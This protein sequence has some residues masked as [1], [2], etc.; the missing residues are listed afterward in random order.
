MT[1]TSEIQPF[2]REY[3]TEMVSST[4]G[5]GKLGHPPT[6][7]ARTHSRRIKVL[8]VGP[9]TG[10]ALEEDTVGKLRHGSQRRVSPQAGETK[11]KIEKVTAPSY[12]VSAGKGNR[13][14]NESQPTAGAKARAKDTSDTELLSRPRR[15]AGSWTAAN[16]TTPPRSGRGT[17]SDVLR[18]RRPRSAMSGAARRFP[19]KRAAP[20]PRRSPREDD[21]VS[22][23]GRPCPRRAVP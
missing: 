6:P 22:A 21:A 14:R 15:D 18:T 11:G 8:T 16:G 12:E 19:R 4:S 7:C 10:K 17:R 13:P 23:L 1:Q 3:T 5:V 9:E 20:T 2:T